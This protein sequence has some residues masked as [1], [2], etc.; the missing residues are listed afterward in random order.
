MTQQL[1]ITKVQRLGL[2][3]LYARKRTTTVDVLILE[4]KR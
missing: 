3:S 1:R 4:I 2:D